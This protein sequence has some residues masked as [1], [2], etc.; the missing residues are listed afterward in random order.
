MKLSPQ[1]GF[2][3]KRILEMKKLLIICTALVLSACSN[4]PH[5][6]TWEAYTVPHENKSVALKMCRSEGRI[7][8]RAAGGSYEPMTEAD[9]SMLCDGYSCK[10]ME[11][12]DDRLYWGDALVKGLVKS[13]AKF[14]AIEECMDDLGFEAIEV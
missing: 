7:A 12:A 10:T 8:S 13:E 11:R 3:D 9:H 14:E 2:E 6:T 1:Y 4:A 5:A